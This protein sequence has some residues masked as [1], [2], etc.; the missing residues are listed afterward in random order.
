MNC[1][2]CEYYQ[3]K[4]MINGMAYSYSNY[5]P[6]YDCKWYSEK[7]D[8]FKPKIYSSLYEKIIL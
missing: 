8:F 3:L 1:K 4:L 6:C 2:N 7:E 5:I